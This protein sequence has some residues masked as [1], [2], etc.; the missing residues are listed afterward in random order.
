[1]PSSAMTTHEQRTAREG[2]AMSETKPASGP[3]P[4]ARPALTRTGPQRGAGGF[5]RSAEGKDEKGHQVGGVPL[6]TA[7][8]AVVAAVRLAYQ[9]AEAQIDRSTRLARRLREAGDK[10]V[11]ASSHRKAV[12]GAEHLVMKSLLSGLEW[13]EGSVAEGRCPVKR[14]AAAEYQM[15]GTILGFG[16][17]QPAK[18]PAP[19][20]SAAAASSAGERKP[21]PSKRRLTVVHK[22]K[23][24]ER[25]PVGIEAWELGAI[26][27]LEPKVYFYSVDRSDGKPIEAEVELRANGA[28][29]RLLIATPP[30]ATAGRWKCAVCDSNDVQVGFIEISL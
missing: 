24:E 2:T 5:Y 26:E 20:V 19:P 8:A 16:P 23:K 13:W 27:A 28:E 9:V 4:W 21:A 22:A 3:V 14:L 15:L 29:V 11:G 6:T 17:S 25:R 7:N 1:M 18:S 12:D 10:E 30:L